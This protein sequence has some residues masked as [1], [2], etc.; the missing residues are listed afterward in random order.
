MLRFIGDMFIGWILFTDTGKKTIN[1]VVNK[2]YKHI[3]SNVLNST[4]MKDLLSLKDI[5]IKDENDKST[6]NN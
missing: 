1:M 2:A 6:T 5:F 3:Q 4:Q